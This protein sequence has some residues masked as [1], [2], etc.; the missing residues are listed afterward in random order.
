MSNELN[1]P[2]AE[3]TDKFKLAHFQEDFKAILALALT[4]LSKPKNITFTRMNEMDV[5]LDNGRL[6]QYRFERNGQQITKIINL[7]ENKET[8]IEW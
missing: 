7:T 4:A 2:K 6:I 3:L 5:L 1:I 8:I